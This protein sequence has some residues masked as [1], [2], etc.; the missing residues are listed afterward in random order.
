MK[1]LFHWL[2]IERRTEYVDEYF[3]IANFRSSIYMSIVI[4]V[5]E[6]WMLVSLCYRWFTGDDSRTIM[7]YFEHLVWYLV[8]LFT[9]IVMI[10]ISVRYLKKRGNRRLGKLWGTIV[11]IFFSGIAVYFG[12][13]ISYSDYIKGEQILCFAMMMIFGY[14]FFTSWRNSGAVFP[15]P[16]TV[17][18][19]SM[20]TISASAFMH[21]ST[22]RMVMV[23]RPV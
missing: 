5:L 3:T 19:Q 23:I 13:S 14:F 6:L 17:S 22:S 18:V 15:S 20:D 9:A 16:R 12:I 2:G 21:S 7:W 4:I 10:R 11:M 8:F 1:K